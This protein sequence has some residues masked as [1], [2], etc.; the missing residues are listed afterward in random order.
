MVQRHEYSSASSLHSDCDNE[1]LFLGH[2]HMMF[3]FRTE[4][5]RY[6]SRCFKGGGCRGAC[7]CHATESGDFEPGQSC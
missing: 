2:T 4:Q 7:Q 3:D 1:Y 5:I 6:G